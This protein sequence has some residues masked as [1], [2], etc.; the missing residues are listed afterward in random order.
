MGCRCD[1]FRE[2]RLAADDEVEGFLAT[3]GMKNRSVTAVEAVQGQQDRDRRWEVVDRRAEVLAIRRYFHCYPAAVLT[4]LAAD[5][6]REQ[7][8]HREGMEPAG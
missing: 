3:L 6:A 1:A 7:E 8:I 2:R 4:R 5:S